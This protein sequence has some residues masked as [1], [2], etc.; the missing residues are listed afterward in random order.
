MKE[1]GEIMVMGYFNFCLEESMEG[2]C[3]KKSYKFYV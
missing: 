3:F 2:L 1:D